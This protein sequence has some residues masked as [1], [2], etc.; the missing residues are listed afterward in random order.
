[1][2]ELN[3][4]Q[5]SKNKKRKILSFVFTLVAYILAGI[6][7]L[8]QENRLNDLPQLVLVMSFALIPII[9]ALTATYFATKDK[10]ASPRAFRDK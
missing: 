1:M 5:A 10:S 2:N 7:Y 9:I 3:N 6:F 4:V 8:W